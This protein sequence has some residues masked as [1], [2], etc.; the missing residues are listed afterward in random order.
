MKPASLTRAWF[1]SLF[2]ITAL[3]LLIWFVGPAIAVAG[4]VPLEHWITRFV[5]V[6]ALFLLWGLFYVRRRLRARKAGREILD[7]VAAAGASG[8][9]QRL[10]DEELVRLKQR[11]SEAAEVIKRS[12]GKSG[13]ASLY[14]LPWYMIIGPPGS[15]KTTALINSGL[16]FPLAKRFGKEAVRGVGGTRNCDWWFTDEAILLDTAGRYTTQ[17]SDQSVDSAAWKGFLGLLKKYRQRRPINGVLVAVSLMDL[18]TADE[19][20]R[21]LHVQAIKQRINELYRY[22]GIRLPVYVLFT[23]ADLIAGFSEFFD[24]LG[25]EERAQVWGTTFPYSGDPDDNALASFD[26]EFNALIE[27]LNDRLLW[28]LQNENDLQ[29]RALIYKFPAQVRA[30][31]QTLQT[32]LS[33]A[34]LPSRYELPVLLRGFYLTSGTQEG[35]PIDRIMGALARNFGL[36]DQQLVKAR[37]EGRSYF[38][39]RLLKEVVFE[40]MALAGT[41][42]R[43]ETRRMWMRRAVF[44]SAALLTAGAIGAWSVSY[45][46]NRQFIA[47]VAEH[48][49]NTQKE[50]DS[51]PADETALLATLPAL[52]LARRIP[53]GYLEQDGAAPLMMTLGLF[54]GDKIN[55][56]SRAAYERLLQKMLLPRYM[57]SVEQQI[58]KHINEPDYLI[59]A[60]KVYL[61]FADQARF[62]P[63][64]IREWTQNDWRGSLPGA[65]DAEQ[66]QALVDHLDALLHVWPQQLPLQLDANLIRQSRQSLSNLPAENRAYS[67][68]K[69]LGLQADLPEFRI[70]EA[71]GAEA[72]LVFVRQSGEPLNRGVPGLYTADGYQLFAE[73]NREITKELTAEAW[74]FGEQSVLG[75]LD[76]AEL[77]GK[78]NRL[79]FKD[80]VAHWKALLA[81]VKLVPFSSIAHAVEVLGV[82]TAPESPLKKLLTAAEGQTTLDEA[83]DVDAQLGKAAQKLATVAEAGVGKA[84]AAGDAG[85]LKQLKD[86][87]KTERIRILEE[88][89]AG[90]HRLMRSAG[91]APAPIENTLAQLDELKV[92]LSGVEQALERGQNPANVTG[93][94]VLGRLQLG[95]ARQPVPLKGII[96]TAVEHG[97]RVKTGSVYKTLNA[98][99]QAEILPFCQTALHGR[100]PLEVNSDSDVALNDFGRFFGPAGLLATFF[101]Q[102]L[103]EHIDN[104]SNPWRWRTEGMSPGSSV[105]LQRA[106]RIKDAFFQD[107][108]QRP[109]LHFELKPVAMDASITRF[110]LNLEGQEVSYKHGPALPVD[111][112]WP[113]PNA[114]SQVRLDFLSLDSSGAASASLEGPWA[115]FRLLD[116]SDLRP[117]MAAGE[118]FDL[119]FSL[120]GQEARYELRASSAI[121]PFDQRDLRNFRCPDR[122]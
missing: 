84:L 20:E 116:R 82:L 41:N 27:R 60:L 119:T 92:Y 72:P 64:F 52:N 96:A 9:Q 54:Q 81:D 35:T 24:D 61:M 113:G 97:G 43:L 3:A 94:D 65:T 39:T 105:Q 15:G 59:S 112:Q 77:R 95:A 91:G 56:G 37:G 103:A 5:V 120:H 89:F 23:K 16:D 108:G 49:K 93:G 66:R 106:K 122:L 31:Q 67:R 51:V 45:S 74:V 1:I 6:L 32:F 53:G 55:P 70:S 25:R 88:E 110:I 68:I 8:D 73:K 34:F 107:G 117:S 78:I 12:R 13:T 4:K 99:W 7:G 86:T 50:I 83:Q 29:R 87:A 121:N 80:Y 114:A 21:G 71:A 109:L 111:V 46:R 33:E 58:K 100:Y 19:Q 79:Y 48:A 98:Y 38:L 63:K 10:A 11:F 57:L 26:N 69:E 14:E 42:R 101:Q 115:W 47:R 36:G 102:Y 76:S 18:M 104:T 90:L 17:D 118:R 22:F 85:A 30:L 62:D 2:G 75:V 40:E 28:R 44:A